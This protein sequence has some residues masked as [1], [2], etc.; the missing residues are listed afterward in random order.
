MRTF[1]TIVFVLLAYALASNDAHAIS[2]DEKRCIADSIYHEARGEGLEG[3]IAVA[4]VIVNRMRS[5]RYPDTACAVVYQYRQFSWTLYKSKLQPV[6]DYGNDYI[7]RIAEL[8]LQSRLIDITGGATHY[9]TAYV[10]PRWAASK[11]QT[12]VI[13]QHIFYRKRK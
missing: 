7:E 1:L 10:N 12:F 6:L 4:N 2:Q 8:A 13:G 3:M 5:S 11:K 9:H